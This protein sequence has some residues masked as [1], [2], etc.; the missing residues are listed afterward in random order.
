MDALGAAFAA[1]TIVLTIAASDLAAETG[2][3]GIGFA[4]SG[5]VVAFPVTA[6]FC[7]RSARKLL[8]PIPAA[9]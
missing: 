8:K 2:T 6:C 3:P 9:F 4:V 7:Y 5:A 1:A